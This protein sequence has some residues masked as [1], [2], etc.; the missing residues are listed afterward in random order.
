M[1]RITLTSV[2]LCTITAAL[3][4]SILEHKRVDL[5]CQL[6]I[7]GMLSFCVAHDIVGLKEEK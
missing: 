6:L 4:V 5:V 1:I 7:L 3:A 2:T